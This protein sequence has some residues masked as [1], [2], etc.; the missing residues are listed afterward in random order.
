MVCLY[1]L[2]TRSFFTAYFFFFLSKYYLINFV[3]YLREII[4][5]NT[6]NLKVEN[7]QI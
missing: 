6:L 5:Y 3:F 2:I 1:K 4:W 7:L